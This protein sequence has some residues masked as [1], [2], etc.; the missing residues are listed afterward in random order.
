LTKGWIGLALLQP[1]VA[2]LE[3]ID[4]LSGMNGTYGLWIHTGWRRK[5]DVDHKPSRG[6]AGTS[7]REKIPM[8][9]LFLHACFAVRGANQALLARVGIEK[10]ASMVEYALL[11]GLIAIVAV[12]TISLLGVSISNLFNST[13]TCVANASSCS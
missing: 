6:G 3:Q 2:S 4:E 10:G 13:N 7:E 9:E 12:V 5:M 1:F 8:T 11:V